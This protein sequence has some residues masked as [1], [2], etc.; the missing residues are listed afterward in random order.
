MSAARLGQPVRFDEAL[1]RAIA[2]VEA[3]SALLGG[4]PVL[5][6]DVY[7]RVRVA[8]DDRQAAVSS[9]V[10]DSV[11][12]SLHAELGAYSPGPS[13]GE[14]FLLASQLVAPDV[15]F[16]SPE[17]LEL[18]Q[19]PQVRLLERQI[20]GQDW[21]RPPLPAGPA[22]CRATFYGVKGG[23]GRSTALTVL[24]KHLAEHE[25]KR[26]LVVDLDLES[27]GVTSMF[28]RPGQ[29]SD[30]GLLDYLVED[31]VGQGEDLLP[32]IAVP[33]P[34]V[35]GARGAVLV[36]PAH[37]AEPGDYLAKLSRVYQ[38]VPEG[39]PDFATRLCHALH[40]LELEHRPDVVLLDSRAGLHDI[41]AVAV[42]RLDALALLFASN[43]QQTLVAYRLLFDSFRRYP[44][45]LRGFRERLQSVAA[46]VP[47]TGRA[48]YLE[49]LRAG[50]HDLFARTVYDEDT[51][52]GADVF[53]FSLEDEDGPHVPL[54]IHWYRWFLDFDP[55]R[56]G[57][58]DRSEVQAAFGAFLTRATQ[59][60]LRR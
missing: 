20:T 37:G 24:A 23:V 46:L 27:P 5:V 25:R 31:A 49:A 29:G 36:V 12:A 53:N 9:A 3:S 39:A 47:E 14:V 55:H 43:T 18:P 59:L 45:H 51:E 52:D 8:I 17:I 35:D 56:P 13:P 10:L 54:P 60:L 38:G 16:A 50:L 33:S 7:G 15:L 30:F 28:L 26:V 41:A 11:A 44:R 42:T 32:R 21:L 6:R 48:A 22:C 2:R 1:R 40:R 58:L 19:S 57:A 34:L 4:R